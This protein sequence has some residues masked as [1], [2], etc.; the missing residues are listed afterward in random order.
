MKLSI[1]TSSAAIAGEITVLLFNTRT[2]A[3]LLHLNTRSFAQH[4]ALDDYYTGVVD[5]ADRFAEAAIGNFKALE[6]PE[7]MSNGLIYTADPAQYLVG[8]QAAL[9]SALEIV[10]EPVLNNIL[11]EV[12]ELV[13]TTLYKLE[14]LS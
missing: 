13:S 2:I 11:A 14:Q 10:T 5:L 1:S 4:K 9:K 6:W 3:H 7:N 12:L 8:V